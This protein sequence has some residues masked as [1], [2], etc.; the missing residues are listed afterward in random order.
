M[1]DPQKKPLE[2]EQL[3]SEKRAVG[4]ETKLEARG[5]GG[6]HASRLDLVPVSAIIRQVQYLVEKDFRAI[7]ESLRHVPQLQTIL[8]RPAPEKARK[9][10]V[11]DGHLRL[12]AIRRMGWSHVDV[13]IVDVDDATAKGYRVAANLRG[14]SPFGRVIGSRDL[15]KGH[16]EWESL[17]EEYLEVERVAAAVHFA[18]VELASWRRQPAYSGVADR[19]RRNAES[20]LRAL[21][22]LESETVR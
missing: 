18:A 17:V 5:L 14:G 2:A 15:S 10:E 8:V 21:D 11:I 12:E 19:I 13:K 16:L 1:A 6:K 4:D 7:L 9:F 22:T 3:D 20:L